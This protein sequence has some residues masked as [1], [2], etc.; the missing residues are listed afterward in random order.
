M[1]TQRSVVCPRPRT[2]CCPPALL[3]ANSVG[4]PSI[5]HLD[6]DKIKREEVEY[7]RKH[8]AP[9]MVSPLHRSFPGPSHSYAS[10]HQSPAASS[11]PGPHGGLLSPPES[12]RT[13]GDEKEQRQP[14]R[15]SLPSIHEALGSEQPLSYS[16][17]PPT[18][19]QLAVAP[20]FPPPSSSTS[21]SDHRGRAFSAVEIGSQGPPNPFSHPRSPFMGT[22]ASTGAPQ[23][24]P[25]QADPL[26]RPSFSST[27]HNPKLPALH[28]LRTTQS[29]PAASSR[30]NASYS[31]YPP[32]ASSSYEPPAPHSAGSMNHHYGYPPYSSNYPLSAPAPGSSNT[33]Y[34]PSSTTYSAPPRYPPPSWRSDSSEISRMEE[35]K[36]GRANLA[37]YGESVKRHLES[38]D[39]EASLNEMADGAGRITDWTMQYR[40]SAHRH[41][42]TGLI[43]GY[44]PRL[45]EVDDMLKQSEKIQMSLQRMRDVVYSHQQANIVEPQPDAHYRPI[46]GYDHEGSNAYPDEAKGGGGFPPDAK[47]RRGRA[48]PPGRC[49][50]CNRAETPEWRRGP[51]GARTLC[52]ACGLHYAKL[53]RKMGGKNA[54]SSSNLRPK[55]LGEG[56]PAA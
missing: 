6:A 16:A 2:P 23:P 56:S 31:T 49:H 7:P 4:L 26:P 45:D 40:N 33:G 42:R 27:P 35:K 48:A 41:T 10:N 32:P 54:M 50:S 18:S 25:A 29:P 38:F 43:S 17:A 1:E 52:N 44:M 19:A 51:D 30:S 13:S 47:K 24:P 55:S 8:S 12:R 46:N 3:T 28:P 37:P 39:L 34:P 15:Q 36:L 14:A 9:A 11:L 5:S 21:P 20:A 22:P 53:T